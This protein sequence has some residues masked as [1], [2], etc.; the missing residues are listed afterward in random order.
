[1]TDEKEPTIYCTQEQWEVMSARYKELHEA[2]IVTQR[3]SAEFCSVQTAIM[4]GVA[5][6]N[7][8]Q[9]AIDKQAADRHRERLDRY[10]MACIC[11]GD[12]YTDGW[13]KAALR[14]MGE[15]DDHL[16]GQEAPK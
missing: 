14:A 15:V 11:N 13:L 8:E 7:L 1:M 12:A 2:Q 16:S 9:A 3:R 6:S 4:I 5:S 10:M